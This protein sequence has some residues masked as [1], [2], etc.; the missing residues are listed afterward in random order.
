MKNRMTAAEY[1]EYISKRKKG[2]KYN[3]TKTTLDG[4]TFDSEKEAARYAE[5][6]VLEKAGAITDLERQKKF[7]LQPSFYYQGKKQRPIIYICDFCYKQ[8][9]KTIIEDV[10]SPITKNNQVY[11]LKKKMMLYKGYEVKEV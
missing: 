10:K 2:D 6:K 9:G 11:K 4:I 5:L 7:I 3:N 1:R 8:N